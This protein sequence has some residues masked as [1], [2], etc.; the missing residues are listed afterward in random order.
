MLGDYFSG[1]TIDFKTL[2]DT[3]SVEIPK[4]RQPQ[5]SIEVREEILKKLD[6][7]TGLEQTN[8]AFST[9]KKSAVNNDENRERVVSQ[10]KGER[11]KT[12]LKG[13]T[14]GKDEQG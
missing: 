2:R 11:P 13:R 1:T 6:K 4:R 3:G 8:Y 10:D 5:N 7:M 14:E 12:T 9:K